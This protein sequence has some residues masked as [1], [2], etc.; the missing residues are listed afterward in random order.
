MVVVANESGI[1][2]TT[3]KSRFDRVDFEISPGYLILS[4]L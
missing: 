2:P 4:F 3:A 1:A